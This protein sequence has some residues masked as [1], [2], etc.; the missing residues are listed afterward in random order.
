M[1]EPSHRRRAVAASAV[2]VAALVSG[3]KST[4]GSQASGEVTAVDKGGVQVA[5]IKGTDRLAF[6]PATVKAKPGKVELTLTVTGGVPHNLEVS[7]VPG[8]SI[9]NVPGHESD[10]VSFTVAAGTYQLI[11]TYHPAMR[12]RLVVAP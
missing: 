1:T 9:A 2:L 8:A 7:G 11:C 3:C 4:A 10:K 6:E 12:G 5:E